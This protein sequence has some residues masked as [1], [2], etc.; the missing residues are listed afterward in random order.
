MVVLPVH[1]HPLRGQLLTDIITAMTWQRDQV[2]IANIVKCRPP[3]NRNPAPDE[4][5]ACLPFL[6]RQI[7]L[8]QPKVIV[9]LGR[10]PLE[11]LFPHV[12][13]GITRTRGTWLE[14]RGIPTMPT[15]H[16]SY[17]LRVPKAKREVWTDMQAVMARFGREPG[18]T[19]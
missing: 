14:Y 12:R 13:T 1:A 8:V 18:A 17:L 7:E 6:D 11:Y 10:V 4:A 3:G 15:F 9:A 2:Y 19:R 16:P 5:A